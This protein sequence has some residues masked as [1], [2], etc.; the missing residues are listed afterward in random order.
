MIAGGF[1]FPDDLYYLVEHQV[2]ARFD[3]DGVATVG[4]T[5][6]GIHLAGDIYMC[7]PKRCRRSLATT[8]P[9]CPCVQT[10]VATRALALQGKKACR[11]SR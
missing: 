3:D 5:S 2:W 9:T 4:I 6:L 1:E 8:R 10:W 7:R 11:I